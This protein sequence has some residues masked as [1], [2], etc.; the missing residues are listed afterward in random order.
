MNDSCELKSLR[1]ARTADGKI[2]LVLICPEHGTVLAVAGSILRQS[3]DPDSLR[4]ELAAFDA[5]FKP[6]TLPDALQ[7]VLGIPAGD[8]LLSQMEIVDDDTRGI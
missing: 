8:R 7:R 1:M 4:D 6:Q 5:T 3:S 2:A